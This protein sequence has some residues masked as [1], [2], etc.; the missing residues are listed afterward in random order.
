MPISARWR[1]RPTRLAGKP[2]ATFCTAK[3]ANQ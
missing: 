2:C 3:I 1:K